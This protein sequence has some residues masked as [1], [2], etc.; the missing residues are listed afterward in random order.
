[1]TATLIQAPD[2]AS[3]P[4]GTQVLA[5]HTTP[6]L[7]VFVGVGATWESYADGSRYIN[8]PAGTS[9]PEIRLVGSSDVS[10]APYFGW[11]AGF[12]YVL[13][14]GQSVADDNHRV[15]EIPSLVW[16]VHR[17]FAATGLLRVDLTT[18]GVAAG[19]TRTRTAGR[20]IH[21]GE[22]V[23][24]GVAI[25]NSGSG[26]V[27]V[28][29][30]GMEVCHEEGSDFSSV[31]TE[32][33]IRQIR[34]FDGAVFDTHVQFPIKVWDDS[35]V[36]DE[37]F[38]PDRS[39]ETLGDKRRYLEQITT[40]E[41][42]ACTVT[43]PGSVAFDRYVSGGVGPLRHRAAATG[44]CSLDLRGA[45]ALGPLLRLSPD[46]AALVFP[47]TYLPSGRSAA[48]LM[49]DTVPGD[50]GTLGFDGTAGGAGTRVLELDGSPSGLTYDQTHRYAT[51]LVF[52][53]RPGRSAV[54]L[55]DQT[56][57]TRGEQR[58]SGAWWGREPGIPELNKLTVQIDGAGVEF[59]LPCNPA[60]PDIWGDSSY[61]HAFANAVTPGFSTPAH[62]A[63]QVGFYPDLARRLTHPSGSLLIAGRS[64]QELT[65]IDE[66]TGEYAAMAYMEG[67]RWVVPEWAINDGYDVGLVLAELRLRLDAHERHNVRLALGSLMPV[68]GGGGNSWPDSYRDN[69]RL[70]NRLARDEMA[71]RNRPD[72]FS[73]ADVLGSMSD[74]EVEAAYFTTG[75]DDTHFDDD[76]DALYAQRFFDL[77]TPVAA[78]R[79][80]R[81][82][83]ARSS[84]L[85]GPR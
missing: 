64:G 73:F 46:R 30:D 76:G 25:K 35:S 38:A 2:A 18:F 49:G 7:S 33:N 63:R 57:N 14:D 8:F 56:E 1:M 83:R 82:V 34:V 17:S 80:R 15:M 84:V 77:L 11:E 58:V 36:V 74:A 27:G 53:E 72:L 28:T 61:T 66:A 31:S 12:R 67:F 32:V 22:D 6:A 85:R 79:S 42:G 65:N 19:T 43:N 55:F 21:P 26:W 16:V 39:D 3:V 9:A 13:A 10:S 68:P 45:H 50:I 29:L 4:D 70:L 47:G 71:A 60:A 75:V 40:D 44:A 51:V 20:E 52:D 24:F 23:R 37:L 78:P 54:L 59:E 69:A 62:V 41:T 81:G 5:S 48:V